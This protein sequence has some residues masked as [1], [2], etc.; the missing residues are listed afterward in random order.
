MGDQVSIATGR[1]FDK[2]TDVI[3]KSIA[4]DKV[5]F[6]DDEGNTY[7]YTKGDVD[8]KTTTTT[9]TTPTDVNNGQQPA[10]TLPTV[11]SK[12]I[13]DENSPVEIITGSTEEAVEASD[14]SGALAAIT[15]AAMPSEHT[16][17]PPIPPASNES[18]NEP[19]PEEFV[20]NT[21]DSP[22]E[23]FTGSSGEAVEASDL[24]GSL[25][26]LNNISPDGAV[27]NEANKEIPS[28]DPDIS[29]E[30]LS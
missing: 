15:G 28:E 30:G 19:K 23:V 8:G 4:P 9:E 12:D 25:D 18:S 24:S 7:V 22:V 1:L 11:E 16:I 29:T 17:T 21:Q 10:S 5:E 26:F 13:V 20:D 27:D 6:E 14:L 2:E 3:I